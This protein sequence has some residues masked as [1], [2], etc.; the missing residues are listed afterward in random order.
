L[1]RTHPA[2][3][4]GTA[5]GEVVRINTTENENVLIISRKKGDKEVI[6]FLNL[7][8]NPVEYTIIDELDV[9]MYIDHFT[10]EVAVALPTKLQAWD[11]KVL[12]KQI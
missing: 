7:S 6:A 2:L 1:K 4:A 11:Y 5:G 12:V 3:A 10:D 9:D 8:N